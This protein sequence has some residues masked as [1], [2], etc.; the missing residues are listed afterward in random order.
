MK[1]NEAKKNQAIRELLPACRSVPRSL[2][3]HRTS[4]DSNAYSILVLE[5]L[6]PLN[7]VLKLRGKCTLSNVI[8]G[9][10]NYYSGL[11]LLSIIEVFF[12]SIIYQALPA[13]KGYGFWSGMEGVKKMS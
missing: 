10:V 4:S 13:F 11:I 5:S 6:G 3:G 12:E 7:R 9:K 1:R 8:R 2:E